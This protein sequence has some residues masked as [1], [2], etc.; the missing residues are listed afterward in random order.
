MK[1]RFE[2]TAF[3]NSRFD[4]NEK[5]IL[6][7]MQNAL[8]TAMETQVKLPKYIVVVLNDDLIEFARFTGQGVSG[9]YGKYLTTLAASL[10]KLI[11]ERKTQLPI[12]AKR[13]NYPLMY[14]V[15]APVH[16]HLKHLQMRTKFNLCL[17]SV[18][19]NMQ[20]MRTIK[21][22]EVWKYNDSKLVCGGELSVEGLS[23]FWRAIDA[24]VRFNVKKNE[25][26]RNSFKLFPTGVD[27]NKKPKGTVPFVNDGEHNGSPYSHASGDDDIRRFFVKHRRDRY[28]WSKN[29]RKTDKTGDDENIRRLP[30]PPLATPLPE[31]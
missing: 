7:R 5:N 19:K 6:I 28:R 26:S 4:S 2:V 12:K 23:C 14:W 10:K 16:R 27:H 20:E 8:I 18:I 9:I 1:T 11:L 15:Q 3:C 25:S 13:E 17:E 22:K 31:E 24:S 21:L 29:Q 30:S